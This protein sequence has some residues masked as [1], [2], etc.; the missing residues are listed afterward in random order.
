ML[1]AVHRFR[2]FGVKYWILGIVSD[3]PATGAMIM[4]RMEEMSWGYWRPSPG[5]IYPLLEEM[6]KAG[7]LKMA[8]KDGKKFYNT[9]ENGKE[10]LNNSWFPWDE[11]KKRH[12]RPGSYEDA[13][14][15]LESY[16]EYMVDNSAEMTKDKKSIERIN[17][18][19]RN[20]KKVVS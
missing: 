9:T 4:D 19:I 8:A 3:K 11:I 13:I 16:S 1:G 5:N 10:Q 12:E 2:G 14:S 7:W 18:V 6:T 17:T 20:L 15:R